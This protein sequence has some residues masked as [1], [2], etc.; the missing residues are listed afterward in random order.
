MEA[1][2]REVA[3][4]VEA[5]GARGPEETL[6]RLLCAPKLAFERRAWLSPFSAR[7]GCL[8]G[9]VVQIG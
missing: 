6:N 2:R 8:G 9:A 1:S 5:Q 4:G 3:E 7:A